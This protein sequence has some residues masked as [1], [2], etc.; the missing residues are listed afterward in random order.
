MKIRW[1]CILSRL[2]NRFVFVTNFQRFAKTKQFRV[3][4]TSVQSLAIWNLAGAK[5]L[6]IV[7]NL[8]LKP[9]MSQF[10]HLQLKWVEQG[11]TESWN[12]GNLSSTCS[13]FRGMLSAWTLRNFYHWFYFILLPILSPFWQHVLSPPL[14][15]SSKRIKHFSPPN[16]QL[17]LSIQREAGQ[18]EI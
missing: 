15:K 12:L 1:V 4:M 8:N 14:V 13:V 16:V 10:S 11:F 17:R 18:I 2:F 9:N 6:A 5:F 7:F 3:N